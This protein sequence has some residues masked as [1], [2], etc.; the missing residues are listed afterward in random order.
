MEERGVPDF[1]AD[2]REFLCKSKQRRTLNLREH[3][4]FFFFFFFPSFSQAAIGRVVQIPEVFNFS[5]L[6]GWR[7]RKDA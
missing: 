3:C 5:F 4:A 6:D 1:G 7:C 2:L